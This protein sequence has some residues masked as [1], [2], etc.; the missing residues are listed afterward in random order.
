MLVHVLTFAVCILLWRQ[1]LGL[2]MIGEATLLGIVM[3]MWWRF[4]HSQE[5]AL[6]DKYYSSLRASKAAESE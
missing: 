3:A 6:Y 4:S 5:K 2:Q 1:S